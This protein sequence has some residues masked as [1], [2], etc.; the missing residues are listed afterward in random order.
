MNRL[1]SK[2]SFAL[3]VSCILFALTTPFCLKPKP[4]NNLGNLKQEYLDGLFLAKPHL[5]TFMGDHR[6][7]ERVVDLSPRGQELRQRVLEQQK[8]RLASLDRRQLALD[9]EIDVEIMS[10]A[11]ELELLYL[12]EIRDWEWDPRLHDSFPYY[13]PREIVASRISDLIHGDFAPVQQRLRSITG[14]MQNLPGLLSQMKS[15]LK[16]PSKIYTQQAIEDNKGRVSLFQTEV[17]EFIA[18]APGIPEDLRVKAETVRKNAVE[19]LES[20]ERFLETELLPRS[21]GDWRL[22]AERFRRKF[23]LALQTRMS[24]D[25][26]ISRAEAHFK[27][28]RQEY[29]DLAVRVH[30]E[31]LPGRVPGSLGSSRLSLAAQ[32]SI[33]RD[34]KGNLSKDHPTAD[35]LVEAHRRNLDDFR[36]F[37]EQHNLL[38]LPPRETLQVKEMPAFKRGVAAAEY[39]APGA[40]EGKAQ[41]QAT[42]Y[43][44]PVNAAWDTQKIESYLRA[45]NIFEVQL[46]AMHE[47][48]P[49]H[50]T[51]YF[52]SRQSL[53]PLRTVLWNAAFVE[54]WAVYGENLMT[55]LG[56]GGEKNPRYRFFELQGDMIVATNAII[57][58]KLHTGQMSEQEAVELMMNEGFQEKAQAEKKLHR[59]QLD[60]TQLSQYFLGYEEILELERDYR[61]KRGVTFNQREFDESLI[62]HGSIAVKYLRKYLL[63]H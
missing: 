45:N 50:H 27:E 7:D 5:A 13:D 34:V 54:G 63:T 53:N 36:N 29:G 52:Y 56:Y 57:D 60:T 62:G 6:F 47:A 9:D 15:C 12:R 21:N 38:Q 46:T 25:E 61:Q 22:G 32:T 37:I 19:A 28:A 10:D 23:P 1:L 59:A 58:I 48:Y 44:D 35:G 55:Q 14:Q 3:T 26:V 17:S 31:L 8:L 51:Q 43:V 30:R 40:L 41:W 33:I 49:G 2:W 42:Y 18:K 4:M 24:L 11:I 16:D 39:L 20:Y